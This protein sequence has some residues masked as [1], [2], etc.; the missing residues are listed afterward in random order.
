MLRGNGVVTETRLHQLVRQ[1]GRVA[2]HTLEITFLDAGV[3]AY[4]FT[5]G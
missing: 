3:R 2:E 4:V 1:T 5:F